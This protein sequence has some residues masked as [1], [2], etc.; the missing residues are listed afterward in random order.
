VPVVPLDLETAT[1]ADIAGMHRVLAAASA[2]DRPGDP[3]PLVED[4]AARL[5]DRREDVRRQRWLARTDD[6]IVGYGGLRLQMLD[7]LHLGLV[8]LVVHPEHRR[9]GTGTALLRPVVATL[10]AEGRRVLVGE[11][12]AGTAGD[13]FCRALGLRPV[14]VDRMSLLR[15]ADV[16]W[17][18]VETAAGT[19]HLGYRLETW[20]D[21]C[22]DELVERY[23]TA[24]TAMNDAPL[25]GLDLTEFVFTAATVRADEAAA[26]ATAQLRVAVAVHED[27]GEIAALTEVQVGRRPHRSH[28]GDTAVV[29][30]HRGRGLGLWVKADMLVRL[31][32]ERPDVAELITGNAVSN[33]HM[34]RIN[35]RLGFRLWS[36]MHGW[37]VDGADLAARLG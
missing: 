30:A 24:K 20:L 25:D 33:S 22:P 8:D 31:R 23:A 36:T 19:K 7:N 13:E 6:G 18:D 28:Q 35:D 27:S 1:D 32:A 17:D 5:R 4:V 29:P 3:P 26:R 34:L 21:R 9:R 16:D 12:N 2:V 11:T 14:Q 10:A 15:L 37:Q